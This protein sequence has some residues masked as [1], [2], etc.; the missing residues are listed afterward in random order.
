LHHLEVLLHALP[1]LGHHGRAHVVGASGLSSLVLLGS[2]VVLMSTTTASACTSKAAATTS[3]AATL[4]AEVSTR[5]GALDLD[6]LAVNGERL[7]QGTLNRL[8]IVEGNKAESTGAARVLVHHEGTI[9]H[10]AELCEE[11]T[12]VCLGGLLGHTS[13]ED[14]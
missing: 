11:L 6:R 10:V 2:K 8:I 13:D 12:E 3:A 14:L 7:R 9:E 5:L 1:V 4:L